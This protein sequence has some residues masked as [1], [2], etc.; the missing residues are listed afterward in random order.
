MAV[1]KVVPSTEAQLSGN[2]KNI[3]IKLLESKY[4]IYFNENESRKNV[5]PKCIQ[6]D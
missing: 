3:K 6:R 5:V 1:P 4:K 2:Y